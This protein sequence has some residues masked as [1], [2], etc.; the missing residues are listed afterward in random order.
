M[1]LHYSQTWEELNYSFDEFEYLM[2]LHYS[3]TSNLK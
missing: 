2:K 3:Q 1:K